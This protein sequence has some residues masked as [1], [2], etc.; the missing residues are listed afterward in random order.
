VAEF[1][2]HVFESNDGIAGK[3]RFCVFCVFGHKKRKS[4]IFWR[5][6]EIIKD[7]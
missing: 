7:I 3:V 6:T 4:S 2:R 5:N 1:K